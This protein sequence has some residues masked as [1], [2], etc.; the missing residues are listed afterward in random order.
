M[1]RLITQVVLLLIISTQLMLAQALR[2][3]GKVTSADTG[4][5]LPGVNVVV[6][7]TSF[8]TATDVSGKYVI[9]VS[10]PDAELV[11]S[12]VGYVSETVNIQGKTVIDVVMIPDVQALS[13][14][15]VIGYGTMERANVTG[16]ISSLK[17][18][19][20]NKIPVSNVVEAL[21]AQV[22]GVRVTKTSGRPGSGV[23][24][25]IRGKKSIGEANVGMYHIG[26]GSRINENEPLI[27]IDG[28]P[29]VGGS[30]DEI[31]INDVA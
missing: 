8:G 12:Y 1:N 25:L 22:P 31:N 18:E 16:A 11:F 3:T 24:I 10:Q 23:D 13:E 15:V 26:S 6:K 4:E 2:I 9:E 19:D 17:S 14:V 28:V 7:G 30:M 21:K 20:I 29:I 27:V 5:P